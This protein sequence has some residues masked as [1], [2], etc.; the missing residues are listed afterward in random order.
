M[1]GETV[2][3]SKTTLMS[4]PG[5]IIDLKGGLSAMVMS[6]DYWL[7]YDEIHERRLA[8]AL[9]VDC[10]RTPRTAWVDTIDGKQTSGVLIRRFP[11]FWYCPRCRRLQDSLYCKY[12]GDKDEKVKLVPPRMVAVC[13]GGHIEDF[14]WRW[15]VG[16][17]DYNHVIEIRPNAGESDLAV[18]C[19]ECSRSVPPSEA[20]PT[21]G[22]RTLAGALGHL[23]VVCRGERPWIGDSEANEECSRRLHGV[24]RA[25][26]NVYFPLSSS[27]ILIPK[28]SYRIYQRVINGQDL[29]FMKRIYDSLGGNDGD[30]TFE[31]M[32]LLTIDKYRK[33]HIEGESADYT[34][35]DF[36]RAFTHYC[37][38]LTN[39][40]IKGD[41]WSALYDPEPP[42]RR[43][44]EVEFHAEKI[45]VSGHPL[46]SQFFAR[47]VLVKMLSE[48]RALNG[49]TRINPVE[50]KMMWSDET[51]TDFARA[52]IREKD[53]TRWQTIFDEMTSG[54]KG[55]RHGY[56]Y[57]ERVDE[58]GHRVAC[59][60]RRWLP[61]TKNKGEGIFFVLNGKRL[62]SWE[63]DNAWGTVVTEI[64][65][66]GMRTL[67][68]MEDFDYSPRGLM[69]HTFSHLLMRQLSKECGYAMASLRE[70][71]YVSR[72]KD[73][74][75]VLV[76]TSAPDA[77]GSLGGLV[78]Q[79]SD[80]DV[81]TEHIHSMIDTAQFCSQDPLC[82]LQKPGST[83][84]PW[85][86]ACHACLHVP[87]T[88]CEGL[89]NRFLDRH[90][91]RGNGLD[92]KGYF[93]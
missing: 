9:D 24:M 5:A 77:Q 43:G 26:S 17:R 18:V 83:G 70:R 68:P 60:S 84:K 6:P 67:S 37:Q 23:D 48:V 27:S 41:E 78:E 86:A 10:F 42:P 73:M 15:W 4:G 12:C 22:F 81:L 32:L 46:L 44:D 79:A 8:D 61:A 28:F 93:E 66:N 80:L 21:P 91:V 14:P 3:P 82:G 38:P 72:T 33:N 13:E 2:R 55:G 30:P 16:C 71:L 39:S 62:A 20:N 54:K 88:S 65:K 40:G 36:R 89:M 69:I 31:K 56:K 52:R 50:G 34:E 63:K 51:Q 49:F 25:G 53:D 57:L 76:Y 11:R 90:S 1:R 59:S 47:I 19:P 7:D 74:C 85:G 35:D 29:D 75:G 92:K 64:M 45:D 87:E 58:H